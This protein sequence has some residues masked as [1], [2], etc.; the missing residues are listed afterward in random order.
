MIVGDILTSP[1][2]TTGLSWCNWELAGLC[3]RF[4]A[5]DRGFLLISIHTL[6]WQGPSLFK[7]DLDSELF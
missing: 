1:K 7:S 2:T 3:Q 4:V 5:D 6:W